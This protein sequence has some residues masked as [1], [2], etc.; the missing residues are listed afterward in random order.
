MTNH[1]LT[2]LFH[3]KQDRLSYLWL[4]LGILLFALGGGKGIIPLATW[5]YPVFFLRFART[6]PLGRG[7]LLVYLAAVLVSV[8][9]LQGVIPFPGVLYYLTIVGATLVVFLGDRLSSSRPC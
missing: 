2:T 5:L 3:N 4:A 9:T 1:K 8:F 6:Q 7:I